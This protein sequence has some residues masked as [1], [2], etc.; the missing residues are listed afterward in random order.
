MGIS[1]SGAWAGMAASNVV[2]GVHIGA[3]FLWGHWKIV[4]RELVN[5]RQQGSAGRG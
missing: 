5:E 4:G 1:V 2:Q 3:A